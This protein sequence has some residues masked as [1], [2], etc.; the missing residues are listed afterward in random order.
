MPVRDGYPGLP[1]RALR[2]SF[3]YYE[4]AFELQQ[5]T[6]FGV[7]SLRY[8]R[9]TPEGTSRMGTSGWFE[10]AGQDLRYAVRGLIASPSFTVVAL[11]TLA[12]GIAATTAIFSTVN[13]TLLRPLPYPDSNRLVDVRTR[14]VDG[15]VR[16]EGFFET[17]GLPMASGRSFTHEE[18][19]PAGRDA[20]FLLIIS[21]PAWVRLFGSD[22]SMVGKAIRF[23]EIPVGITIVG[24]ASPLADLPGNVDFWFNARFSPTDTPHVI[25]VVARLKPG[26]TLEQLVAD[27]NAAMNQ[28][29]TTVVSAKGREWVMKPLV[30]SLVGDLGPVL[31]IAL[32]ATGLL[33]ALACVNVTNL[34]LARGVGRTREMALRTALGAGQGRIIRQLLTESMVLAAG[35][36]VLGFALAALA[37]RLLLA[38]GGSTLPRLESVPIDRTVLLFGFAVLTVSGMIMGIMPAWRLSRADVRTLL[39]ESSRNTSSGVATSRVMSSLIVAEIALAIALVAGAG[40]LLQSFSRLRA[41]DPGFVPSGRLVVDVRATRTFKEPKEGFAYSADLFSRMRDAAPGAKV[42]GGSTVPLRGDPVN[43]L[44]VELQG[45]VV[46]PNKMRGAQIRFVTPG[47]FEALGVKLISGRLFTADDRDTTERVAVVNR[48]FVRQYYPNDDPLA[49]AFFYGYPQVDRKQPTR[50]VGVVDDVRFKSLAQA[51]EPAFYTPAAQSGF[52]LLRASI[53]VAPPDGNAEALLSPM[54][55]ALTRFDPQLVVKLRTSDSIFAQTTQRQELGMTLMLVFG[56]MALLLAGVGIYG[57]IAY[58]AEQRRTELATRIALGAPSSHVFQMLLSTGQ[59]L[60]LGG[61]LIGVATAY[62]AGRVV[63]SYLYEMRAADPIVLVSAC[64]IVVA[65]T[66]AATLIPAIRASRVDPVRALRAE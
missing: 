47:Y 32:G 26:A 56:A 15:R 54:R 25:N 63:A 30:T 65:V 20:P 55:D 18:L 37:V 53:V 12:L 66:M 13:A 36:A 31:L 58:A 40:W 23:A 19:V 45:E 33:L 64:A 46:D 34:L 57:V 10:S 61:V 51:D 27:G 60:A 44:N 9:A 1:K 28:L 42:G 6:P 14:L 29:G 38:L 39:N 35:G 4:V 48:A 11:L 52:P 41:V 24:V 43:A 2:I 50:I 62:A 16:T 21:H 17:L 49:G 7:Y 5:K 8:F 22:P 3:P 59:K